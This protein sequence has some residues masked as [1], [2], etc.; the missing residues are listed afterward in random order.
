MSFV[1]WVLSKSLPEI[2]LLLTVATVV[3]WSATTGLLSGM[4]PM[5][6]G[7]MFLQAVVTGIAANS[8]VNRPGEATTDPA[9]T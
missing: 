1:L 8:V 9:Q 5:K 3:G 7:M 6:P 4:G 2:A